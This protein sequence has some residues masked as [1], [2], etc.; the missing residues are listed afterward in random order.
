LPPKATRASESWGETTFGKHNID[1]DAHRA[2]SQTGTPPSTSGTA[3]R[4]KARDIIMMG[5]PPASSFGERASKTAKLD[6]SIQDN[7]DTRF[8]QQ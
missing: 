1:A 2:K 5:L 3:P 7:F 6:E 8:E 4:T